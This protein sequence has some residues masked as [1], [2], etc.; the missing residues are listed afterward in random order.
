MIKNIVFKGGGVLGIAYAGAIRELEHKGVLKNIERVAGT[1]AGAIIAALLAL[2]FTGEEIQD[3]VGTTDFE[4]FEDRPNPMRVLTKY[5]FY[6]GDAFLEWMR[7]Q[8]LKKGFGPETTFSKLCAKGCLDLHVFA[9]DLNERGLKGFSAAETPNTI[10]AEAIR[11][12][13]SIPFFFKA[14]RF[15]NSNPDNHI[16]VDGGAVYNYPLNVFDNGSA[17]EETMGLFLTDLSG[18]KIVRELGFDDL[19]KYIKALTNTALDS[20]NINMANDADEISRT[21]MI[22]NMGIS[23]TNF[24]IT[25]A[26]KIALFQSGINAI[27]NSTKLL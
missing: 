4:S 2:K 20:Q 7:A 27:K 21:I 5:G 13:M 16:Y 19:V 17:N 3:I 10:V 15:S 26:E 9:A 18:G 12:S 8:L 22:D 25:S 23:A 1:S 14:H 6:S 11:A 24:K